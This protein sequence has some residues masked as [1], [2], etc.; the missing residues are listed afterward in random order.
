MRR[1]EIDV[2]VARSSGEPEE[3]TKKHQ[4]YNIAYVPPNTKYE[5]MLYNVRYEP[6][7]NWHVEKNGIEDDAE[8]TLYDL[9]GA[10][11][12]HKAHG[13]SDV[14]SNSKN[15]GKVNLHIEIN[16]G[17]QTLIDQDIKLNNQGN[18]F[19]FSNFLTMLSYMRR[20][21]NQCNP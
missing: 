4:M 17:D 8:T 1:N 11:K 12:E 20:P 9:E 14:L 16:N 6:K 3:V 10:N 7:V 19:A 15:N 13:F 5:P 2:D 18:D 21:L